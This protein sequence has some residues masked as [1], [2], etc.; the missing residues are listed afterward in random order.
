M[1]SASDAAVRAWVTLVHTH[2]VALS[3]V[4]RALKSAGLPPL[5]WYD[6]LLELERAGPLRPRELQARLLFAQPNLS[7]LLDRM[8][9]AE[10]VERGRCAEDARGQLVCLG[11]AGKA[12][13]RRMWPIYA[14]A[15]EET[16]GAKLTDTQAEQLAGLLGRLKS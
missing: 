3:A 2:R 7:R 6:V 5:D 4:E 9:G 11:A 10:L 8:E 15:I 13:R 16:V 12:L 1:R 14:A